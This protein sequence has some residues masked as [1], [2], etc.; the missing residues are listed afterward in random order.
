MGMFDFNGDGHTD[1][2][3]Q[4]IGYQIFKDAPGSGSGGGA[5]SGGRSQLSGW[6]IFLIVVFVYAILNAMA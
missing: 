4:F 3:E 1:F 5:P 2:G 6:D